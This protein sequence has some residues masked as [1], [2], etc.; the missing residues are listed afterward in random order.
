VRLDLALV[1]RHPG[2]SRRKAQDV[3]AKGQVTVDGALTREPGLAV[4]PGSVLV[5]DPNRRAL[6]RARLRLRLLYEDDHV[7]VV[8]KPA[9]L[10]AVPTAP[11]ATDEDTAL[12]RVRDYV[13]R[14]RPR[15]TY[16][17]L[18][19]RIDRDTSGALVFALSPEARSGLIDAFRDHRIERR[20]VALV[21]GAPRAEAGSVDAPLREAYVSGR[22][23]VA[24]RGEPAR[25]AL[26]RWRVRERFP[27]ASLLE[28]ELETGRQHQVRIHLAHVG[29]PVL[30]DEVYGG[31]APSPV[32]VP[33]QMLH[34]RTLAFAHPITGEPVRADS[35]LPE[36]F[37]RVVEALRR[38]ASKTHREATV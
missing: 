9:G 21:A 8:D 7:L 26:T 3:I 20:Y 28:V 36:D 33:R 14:L 19:H 37:A 25:P 34:A 29:L 35:P 10:L 2:L 24:R 30:G 1:R 31:K 32:R 23:G 17:G 27:R 16:V 12:S 11:G 38:Q 13:R 6:P 18:V 22:R 4:H 5:W 15:Q